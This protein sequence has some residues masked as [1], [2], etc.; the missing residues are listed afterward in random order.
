MTNEVARLPMLHTAWSAPGFLAP[1][2][3]L[4]PFGKSNI[5]PVSKRIGNAC[6]LDT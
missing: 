4:L 3:T 2:C 6:Q 5:V 1:S